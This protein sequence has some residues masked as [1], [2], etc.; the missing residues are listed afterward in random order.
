[1]EIKKNVGA[2]DRYIRFMIGLAFIMNIFSLELNRFGTFVLLALGFLIWNTA[3]TG[4]CF[5]YDVLGINTIGEG[6]KPEEPAEKT[7]AH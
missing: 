1:M 7:A 5:I 2:S 6:K 3:Y 4:Y